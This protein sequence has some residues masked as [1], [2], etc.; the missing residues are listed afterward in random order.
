MKTNIHFEELVK[1]MKRLRDKDGCPW[2]KEQTHESL[3]PHLIEETYEVIDAIDSG[4][5]D[6]LKEELA[7]LLYQILFHS[8]ISEENNAFN[9]NDVLALGLEK[10]RRRHPHVF[11]DA[12][13]STA[14]EVI[15]QW[16]AIKKKEQNAAERRYVVDG[17]PKHLPAL[18]KAHKL[19]KRVARVGFDWRDIKDVIRKVEEELEEFK[20]ALNHYNSKGLTDGQKSPDKID[21]EKGGDANPI[22]EELGDMLFAIVNLARFLKLDPETILHKSIYKFSERFRRIEDALR[23]CGKNIEDATL[24]EMDAIWNRIKKGRVIWD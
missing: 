16:H 5:E 7:D 19:Q 10:M 11:G 14:E 9:I 21:Q 1:L 23:A 22:E 8:Q 13:A 17:L 3:K 24:E 15:D 18:Q 6:K 20:R 4:N 12:N 2:D